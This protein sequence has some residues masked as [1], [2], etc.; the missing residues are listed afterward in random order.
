MRVLIEAL[1]IHYTGGGRSAT[2]NLLTSL[3]ALDQETD[4]LVLLSQPEPSLQTSA[5][6]VRQIIAPTRNRFALRLWAQSVV[7][8]LARQRDLV[9]FVKNLTVLGVPARKIVTLYDMTTLLYPDLFPRFDVW[10]WRLVQPKMLR[11]VDRIIAISMTTAQDLQR[12]YHIPSEMIT[13]IYPACASH[14]RPA[15][16]REIRR[17]W[18]KY[19]LPP[20]VVLH[21]G[22]IDR[23]KNLTTLV[24]A[25]ARFQ[26]Q[27]DFDG[28]L[29]L[30]GEE[31]RKSRDPALMETINA[32]RLSDRVRFTGPVS[33]EDLP[34]LYSGATIA[35]F[36]SLHEG[37]G[38]VAV[39]AMAC[40]VPLVVSDAGALR[41]V[42]GDAALVIPSP[43]DDE[44]LAEAMTCLWRDAELRQELRRRGLQLVQ[45]FRP[46]TVAKQTMA[47]YQEVVGTFSS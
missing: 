23:K 8:I 29:V 44:A 10:F 46:E 42:V 33:D 38:I 36:P 45:R 12:L 35:A 47:L 13:I 14:F 16:A 19:A 28:H 17:V 37:F 5:G 3:F 27:N 22:R 26:Q 6:N 11:Q 43:R 24:R 25:F 34:A 18:E 30:V 2:L 32:L 4:Y 39:E 20:H 40:G 41:E 1:G 21:V 7:P 15:S 9:H 31:Y